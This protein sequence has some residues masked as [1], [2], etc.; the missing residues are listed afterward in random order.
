MSESHSVQLEKVEA[1]DPRLDDRSN[2]FLGA[3]MRSPTGSFV[4]RIRNISAM[5][6]LV[7]GAALPGEGE[8]ARL[9]RGNLS[10]DCEVAWEYGKLRGLR[11]D[12]SVDVSAWVQRP[13]DYKKSRVRRPTPQPDVPVLCEAALSESA[14]TVEQS[15]NELFH[16]CELMSL[17]P[18]LSFEMRDYVARISSIAS[19]LRGLTARS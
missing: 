5:G 11:F 4:V 17:S 6:A 1:A 3:T 13:D 9:D 16:I 14:M 19:S 18:D 12:G 2:V 8:R 7:E 10:A 15:A